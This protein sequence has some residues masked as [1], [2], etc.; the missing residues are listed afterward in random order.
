MQLLPEQTSEWQSQIISQKRRNDAQGDKKQKM[1]EETQEM[2]SGSLFS[3]PV[4]ER[5][6]LGSLYVSEIVSVCEARH[7][8]S[9]VLK[10]VKGRKQPT[11]AAYLG[12][13]IT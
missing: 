10:S 9:R 11:A 4:G 6:Q 1:C 5:R 2:P 13:I 7:D 3:H 8:G 12:F